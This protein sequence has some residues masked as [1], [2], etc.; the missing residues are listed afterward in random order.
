MRRATIL[1]LLVALSS[2]SVGAP[3]AAG[4]DHDCKKCQDTGLL[5]CRACKRERCELA[6]EVLYCSFAA[7]CEVCGGTTTEPCTRCGRAPPAERSLTLDR[8]RAWLA[9]MGAEID[10][11]MGRELLHAESEHFLITW[12]VRRLDVEGGE[13]PHGAMHVY[14]RRMEELWDDFASDLEAGPGDFFEK[15]KLF[16]W[17]DEASQEL[18]SLRFTRQPSNTASKLMGAA[19]VVSIYY[20]K[21]HLH[22]E[23]ELHQALVHHVA[24]CLL[25]N[26]F[27]GIWPGNIGG[28][29]IDAGLAH[30]YEIELFDGVRHYCYVETDT[31]RRFKFGQW[32]SAV[33][34][35]VDA[36]QSLPFLG[37]TGKNTGELEPEEHM[38]SWSFV[39]FLLR[40][41]PG[42]FPRVARALK[43]KRPVTDALREALATTPFEFERSW[44]EFVKARYSLKPR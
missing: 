4:R 24:H 29:W 28:G 34:K 44:K 14:L 8:N 20:D 41:H 39:D 26:V 18:G 37:V 12:D 11:V 33:R 9:R 25:S 2:A 17:D 42:A 7:S 16:V 6:D 15:T 38:Y 13:K 21:S 43:A 40:E 32:E 3:P 35:A 31:I 22:T 36:D 30:A 10:D 19:P 23:P 5:A 1:T 27:D